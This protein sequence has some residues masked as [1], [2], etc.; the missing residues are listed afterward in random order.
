MGKKTIKTERIN[1]NTKSVIDQ[2]VNSF[3]DKSIK[4]IGKWKTAL[5]LMDHPEKPRMYL[6]HDLVKDLGVDGHYKSL[7]RLRKYTTLN[8]AFTVKDED[9]INKEANDFFNQSWFFDFLGTAIDAIIEGHTLLEFKYFSDKEAKFYVVPRRNVVP[10][11][12]IIVPDLS[13]EVYIDFE[14]SNLE[15]WVLEIGK[16]DDI[17]IINDIIPNLIWKR[18]VAQSWMEFCEKFG[19]PMVTATTNTTDTEQLDKIEYLLDQLGEAASAVFPSG[20][21]IDYKEANRTDAYQTYDNF[22]KYNKDEMSVNIV[23]GTMITNDG[24]SRS[25]SEVHERNLDEKIAAADK[26]SIMFL[27]NDCLI[28]LLIKQGYSF[29]SDRSRLSF[30]KSHGLSLKDYWPIVEGVMKDYEV[31]E[32]FITKVFYIPIEGKKKRPIITTNESSISA[33][34]RPQYSNSCCSPLKNKTE[35]NAKGF[36]I[37]T[38]LDKL[39]NTFLQKIWNSDNYNVEQSNILI[40]EAKH[41]TNGLFKGWGERRIEAAWNE[42]DHLAMH[43]ME[44]NLYEFAHTKTEARLAAINELLI[45]K[46]KLEIRTYNQFEKLALERVNKLNRS[47]LRT[48]HNLSIAIGQ[49]AS[50][51]HRALSEKDTVTSYV[52]YQTAGDD[53]VRPEHR[54][55]DG[56]IFNLSDPEAMRLWP[57]NAYGCRCEMVQYVGDSPKVTKGKT[58]INTLGDSFKDSPF[59]VNFGDS[60]KVFEKKQL[61]TPSLSGL[62][63]INQLTYQRYG[64]KKLTTFKQQS[65]NLNRDKTITSENVSDL[66]IPTVGTSNYMEY[67]DYLERKL[68]ISKKVFDSHTTGKYITENEGFRHQL[69]PFLK[70]V[71]NNPDEVWL[72]DYKS[73]RFNIRYIKVYKNITLVVD[74]KITSKG[75]EIQTWYPLEKDENVSRIG[76]LINKK[77]L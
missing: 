10:Q 47:Y 53:K 51:Y 9:N 27:V 7:V 52:Q 45:D 3:K 2:I 39:H 66:F 67:N 20:T 41:L 25:Q 49:G 19:Q 48:E 24:A 29:L 36:S 37:E 21:T 72:Q 22:I 55:L 46:D 70:D 60:R 71:L 13:K 31:P 44:F 42:P 59:N 65:N 17:G 69:F 34:A 43:Y 18:N 1:N 77:G 15:D 35:F 61:Y 64:L 50:S 68:L 6:Y 23:G 76:L 5:T 26:R 56:K 11:K 40:A 32:D 63:N 73:N 28:P 62:K 75:L 33:V 54:I 74:C 57:P 30:D 16:R 4:D 12:H 8:S 38:E 58:A 14:D